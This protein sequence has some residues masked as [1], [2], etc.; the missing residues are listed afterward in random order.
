[1]RIR[2][3][4]KTILGLCVTIATAGIAQ[5]PSTSVAPKATTTV[6]TTGGTAGVLPVFTGTSS[7]GSSNLYYT[8][9][10]LGIGKV[11]ATALD[12]VGDTHFGGVGYFLPVSTATAS[13]GAASRSLRLGTSVYNSS[14]S[15]VVGP[16]LQFT[17]EPVG[18]NTSSPSASLHL[19]Y[20]GGSGSTVESG[21]YLNADG[22]IHFAPAQTFPIA[23]GPK[24]PAGPQGATGP[25]G[26]TGPAGS[27][28]LPFYGTA[29]TSD[30]NSPVFQIQN[31]GSGAG[32]IVS[33]GQSSIALQAFGTG[34]S[35]GDND[36][37]GGTGIFAS[38]GE[39]GYSRD[40]A[41]GGVGLAVR[42]GYG[43][44][45]GGN[46]IE[47]YGGSS[48]FEPAGIAIYAVGGT[49]AVMDPGDTTT[50]G[51]FVGDVTIQGNLSKSGGSFKIDDPIDPANKYLYHSFIE[52]P[53]MM[54]IYNGNVTTD[55][56][57]E[58][59]VTMPDY[60]EAL[61][62]DFRYQLTV[63][64]EEFAQAR[65]ASKITGGIFRIRTDKPNVEISWMVTG[66]RQ[67][68]WANAHRIPI[69]Q[70]KPG[71]EKGRYLHPELFGQPKETRISPVRNVDLPKLKQQR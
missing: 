61:N 60:F 19:L 59:I 44:D 4:G 67:D 62:R 26:P 17:A 57:G 63:M 13:K 50:A 23:A 32:M 29:S 45:R 43:H 51:Y 6:T 25:A 28:T 36:V 21:F 41:P 53:D 11:P 31:T 54:N 33:G 16:F 55:G 42:G 14:S 20:N 69:E 64:G 10:R 2:D 24:G 12:V 52:S 8:S 15:S 68:A 66:I 34:S 58:A 35:E 22:T 49:A 71:R 39:G 9:G 46:A 70:E 65:I 40:G 37:E 48:N 27:L 18:N 56:R 30:D 3:I 38:G 7:I 5:Q 47:A 1:M